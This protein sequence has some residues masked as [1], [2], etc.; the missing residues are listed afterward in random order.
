[1][2]GRELQPTRD[3]LEGTQRGASSS[4]LRHRLFDH[5]SLLNF[6]GWSISLWQTKKI[7]ISLWFRQSKSFEG[8]PK[9]EI[10]EEVDAARQVVH[11]LTKPLLLQ[12]IESKI[13]G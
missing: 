8:N 10:C 4:T 6:Q 11:P 1:V 13:T 12:F 2:T 5:L 9:D 7:N 3:E